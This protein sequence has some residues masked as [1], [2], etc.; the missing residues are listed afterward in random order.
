[1]SVQMERE[2]T[3]Y[4]YVGITGQLPSVSQELA[5]L[6]AGERPIEENWL[7]A[8]LINNESHELW[9]DASTATT[10]DYFLAILI[11]SFGTGHLLNPGAYQV[12]V[13]LTDAFERPVRIVPVALEV[14]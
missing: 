11:G 2:S 12:W 3:E 10:G 13:R 5:F 1:M 14:L 6:A 9:A 8:I 4:L 7:E